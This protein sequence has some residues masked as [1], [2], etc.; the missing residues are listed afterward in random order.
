MVRIPLDTFV[1][2]G[3]Q[4][5]WKIGFHWFLASLKARKLLHI[6]LVP[7]VPVLHFAIYRC[8]L[9]HIDKIVAST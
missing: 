3:I 1:L 4:N 8:Q 2:P 6:L 7:I 9:V 5:H